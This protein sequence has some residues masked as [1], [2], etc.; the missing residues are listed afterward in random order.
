MILLYF[1][2]ANRSSKGAESAALILR[3]ELMPGSE[4][5]NVTSPSALPTMNCHL[6]YQSPELI[7][8]QKR[9]VLDESPLLLGIC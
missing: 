8:R 4:K 9:E 7:L 5:L 1:V 3:L 2:H 6:I